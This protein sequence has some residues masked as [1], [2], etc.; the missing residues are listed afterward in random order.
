MIKSIKYI[1]NSIFIPL[2]QILSLRDFLLICNVQDS[3]L[4]IIYMY[5][6]LSSHNMLWEGI[7]KSDGRRKEGAGCQVY[8]SYAMT[9]VG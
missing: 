1:E 4:R 3:E 5:L 2:S 9:M 8:K 7:P 6:N